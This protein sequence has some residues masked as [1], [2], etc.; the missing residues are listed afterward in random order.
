MT[1]QKYFRR[2]QRDKCDGDGVAGRA[3]GDCARSD[4]YAVR[5]DGVELAGWLDYFQKSADCASAFGVSA[6]GLSCL[7]R[8]PSER[9]WY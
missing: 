7:L 5:I 1:M 6:R 4:V 9:I 2:A 3:I 8:P